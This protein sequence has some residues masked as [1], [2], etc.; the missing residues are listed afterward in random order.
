MRN[1]VRHLPNSQINWLAVDQVV[2]DLLREYQ[3][4]RRVAR[5][6]FSHVAGSD[7]QRSLYELIEHVDRKIEVCQSMRG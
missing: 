3:R 4:L 6:C 5:Q 7:Q 1:Q 2:R